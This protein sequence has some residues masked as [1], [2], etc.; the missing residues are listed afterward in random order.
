MFRSWTV[1]S[2]VSLRVLVHDRPIRPF[3]SQLSMSRIPVAGLY[4]S[5]ISIFLCL[6]NIESFIVRFN[7][8]LRMFLLI[9]ACGD[10]LYQR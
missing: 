2:K 8:D 9:E 7:D 6:S 10:L 4:A 1:R 5:F 3:D